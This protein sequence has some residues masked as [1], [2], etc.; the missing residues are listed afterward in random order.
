[1]KTILIVDD[2]LSMRE[3][4]EILLQKEGYATITAGNGEEALKELDKCSVDLVLT[5]IRMPAMDGL[6]LLA[7]IKEK[8]SNMPVVIMTAFASPE[9]AVTAMKDGAYDYLTK[10]FKVEDVHKIISSAINQEKK[11]SQV[12]LQKDFPNIIGNGTEIKKIFS[13]IK[14]IAPT[15]ANVLIYGES[16]TGKEL[17]ANAIHKHSQVAKAPFVPITCSSIPENLMESELFGHMKGSFTGA[18]SDKPGLFQ[19]ADGGTAFLDEIGELPL[20]IQTKLLRVIQEREITPV[21]STKVQ[22]INVRIIAA[23]NKNLEQEVIKNNFREDL[24]YRL[25]VV[26]IQVPPLRERKEDI[27]ALVEHFLKKYS[28]IMNK[29]VAS[30]SS[31]GMEVLMQYDFPGNVR[32]LENIIERGVAMESSNII[33]PDSLTLSNYKNKDNENKKTKNSQMFIAAED[34]NELFSRGMDEIL[35]DLEARFIKHALNKTNN[36]KVD[37]AELLKISFRSLRY[38]IKKYNIE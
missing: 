25:S 35:T 18:V 10:P 7:A 37:A 29:E 24:Y 16:G 38:K 11:S 27:P 3:F 13:L 31:Y 20:L 23:T 22:R 32:E 8:D 15:P 2:E 28:R 12:D 4:L 33:L 9:D 14:K 26:P 5:D 6:E 17:I 34:E 36:S 19:Q 30:I 21:G 1:M